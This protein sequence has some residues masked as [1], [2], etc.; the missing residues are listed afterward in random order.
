MTYD[1]S[2]GTL[3]LKRGPFVSTEAFFLYLFRNCRFLRSRQRANK[4]STRKRISSLGKHLKPAWRK[5]DKETQLSNKFLVCF[6]FFLGNVRSN[7]RSV[8]KNESLTFLFLIH[9]SD[10]S[11]VFPMSVTVTQLHS[12]QKKSS[13]L[14]WLKLGLVLIDAHKKSVRTKLRTARCVSGGGG[15]G[16]CY[17]RILLM[18]DGDTHR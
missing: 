2:K 18:W 14:W 10:Q 1:R 12:W 9:T 3:D 7:P 17:V 13:L 4:F 15:R 11:K 5:G 8:E 6:D 16:C